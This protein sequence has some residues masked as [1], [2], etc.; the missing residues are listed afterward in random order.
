MKQIKTIEDIKRV[1]FADSKMAY[2]ASC[3]VNT[4]PKKIALPDNDALFLGLGN[5]FSKLG[6]SF[7]GTRGRIFT[8]ADLDADARAYMLG[9]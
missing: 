7:V 4:N 6:Q 1:A 2:N 5:V 3:G 8:M 9:Q